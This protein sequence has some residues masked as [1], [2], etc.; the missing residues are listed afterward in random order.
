MCIYVCIH[1]VG[2]VTQIGVDN[3]RGPDTAS[4][5]MRSTS[6]DV[7]SVL[8]VA[9][10]VVIVPVGVTVGVHVITQ[11]IVMTRLTVIHC[12]ISS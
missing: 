4:R 5:V 9:V 6:V 1:I 8:V 7:L 12:V 11:I 10:A 3:D 2:K